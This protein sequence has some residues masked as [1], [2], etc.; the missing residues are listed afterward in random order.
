MY[1]KP[2]VYIENNKGVSQEFAEII[3]AKLKITDTKM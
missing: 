3:M 1:L 2:I